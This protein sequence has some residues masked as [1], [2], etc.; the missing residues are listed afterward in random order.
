MAE[1]T[2]NKSSFLEKFAEVSAKVGSEVHLMAL[3]DAFATLTPLYILAGVAVLVNNVLF[4][5]F[6]SGDALTN[7][8]AWG[9]ALTNGTLNISGMLIA[10]V[11]GYRLAEQKVFSNPLAAGVTSVAALIA[12]MPFN[13]TAS[14]ADGSGDTALV[15]GALSFGNLGTSSMFS[16]IIIGLLA[17]EL[18]IKLSGIDKLKINL[19]DEVPPAVNDSFNVMIPM[20]LTLSVFGV[21]AAVFSAFGS[22]LISTIKWLIQEPLRNVNTSLPGTI[23]LYFLGNLLFCLGIHQSTITGVLAEPLLTINITDNMATFAA[24]VPL[25]NLAG[26]AAGGY[27]IMNMDIVN[28]FALFGGSGCTLCLVIAVLL[29][30]HDKSSKDIIK[31]ASIPS[32]FNIN[33]PIIFGYPIVFNLPMFIPF[34]LTPTIGMLISY[35]D[36]A[37]GLMNPCVAMVPWTTPVFISGFLATGGDWRAIVVQAIILVIGVA[38]YL[39]FM[40]ISERVAAKQA[41]LDG[42]DA[43]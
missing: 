43:E 14:L 16:G 42:E 41:A 2:E 28:Q 10:C 39:P 27:N 24:G 34:L 18:F 5:L 29:F 30:S 7:V 32:I 40:K 37:L 13:I 22:D 38:L 36:T 3:R 23:L 31:M 33:E 8:Q 20:L 1:A 35:G 17:T 11:A 25:S 9:N 21:F 19:G 15:S 6:L 26:S 12:M 4:P